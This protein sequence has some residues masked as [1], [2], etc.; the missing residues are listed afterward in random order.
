MADNFI[1]QSQLIT[2]YGPGAMIDLPDYSVIVSGLQDWSTR[3]QRREK[4][5]E[6]RLVAKL[7]QLLDVPSLELYTPPRH[8]DNST[9][10][11]PIG[12]RISPP[13]LLSKTQNRRR[14][15]RSGAGGAWC[16]GSI[17]S[18]G[19]SR[20]GMISPSRSYRCVSSAGA[21]A[22]ISPI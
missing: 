20:M 21:D 16:D 8:E 19:A 9:Q 6:A 1:R 4:I 11:A 3:P 13:G 18:A 15:T 14:E 17:W 10:L 12:A 2:T 7:S 22:V 5:E